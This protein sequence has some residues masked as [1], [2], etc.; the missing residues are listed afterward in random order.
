MAK[1]VAYSAILIA[2]A[3]IFSYVEVLIPF[4]FGIP[5]IKLGLANLV[6]VM[7]LYILKPAQTL[8]IS[9]ARI[10]LVSF[11]FGSMSSM[12]YSLAGGV[13]S[14]LVMLLLRK[15]KGFSVMGVSIA[16]GVS[17]NVGQLL[18]AAVVVENMSV[19][20]YMPVLL[21]AGVVTGML[22]GVVAKKVSMHLKFVS[23]Y[24]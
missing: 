9:I 14:F 24:K 7:A 23:E 22:I 15:N 20:Y 12:L 2:L 19:F 17:H 11:L 13:L 6:V 16:G 8:V 3:M 4:H 10:V 18:V 1:R 21:V 5:G